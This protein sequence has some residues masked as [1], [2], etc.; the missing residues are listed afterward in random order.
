MAGA[1]SVPETLRIHEHPFQADT[2]WAPEGSGGADGLQQGNDWH[3]IYTF[4]T[5]G[6][7]MQVLRNTEQWLWLIGRVLTYH[8]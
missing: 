6:W 7:A 1:P 3:F 8:L 4:P 2:Q 5:E